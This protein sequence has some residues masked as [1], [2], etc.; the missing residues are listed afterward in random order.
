MN[1][2]LIMHD[3]IHNHVIMNIIVNPSCCLGNWS[4]PSD[5]LYILSYPSHQIQVNDLKYPFN[6]KPINT[7]IFKKYQKGLYKDQ[8]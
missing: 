8:H 6:V 1:R 2:V 4:A 7:G 5:Y 3:N